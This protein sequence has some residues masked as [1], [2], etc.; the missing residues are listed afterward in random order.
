MKLVLAVTGATGVHAAEILMRKSPWPIALVASP[1]GRDVAARECGSFERLAGLAHEVFDDGNLAASISSG[2]VP[3]V[4]MAILPCSANT[5]GKVAGGI[6]DSLI[7]RAAHC[8]LKERRPLLLCVRELPWTA[9][10]LEN[11]HRVALA[12]GS[13]VPL[14]PPFYMTDGRPPEEVTMAELLSLYVDRVLAVL[15][16]P[17][18][19]NWESIS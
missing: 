3:T 11:A 9:I 19:A 10:D 17:P 2:S 13:I 8:H 15:G 16:H 6:A 18:D 4:G 5:L 12:G 1:W 7:T 14:S